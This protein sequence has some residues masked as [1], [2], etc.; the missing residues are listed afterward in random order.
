M[1]LLNHVD[2]FSH[3]A[4]NQKAP[5]THYKFEVIDISDTYINEEFITQKHILDKILGYDTLSKRLKDSRQLELENAIF[6]N[7]NEKE[8]IQK[9]FDRKYDAFNG[10]LSNDLTPVQTIDT[11]TT[12]SST[13]FW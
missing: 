6:Q 10:I 1:D 7:P 13:G 5:E 2:R 9:I 11:L 12:Y 3:K 4:L 8:K